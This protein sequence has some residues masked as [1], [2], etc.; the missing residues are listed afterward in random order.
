[1]KL[2][3]TGEDDL[4]FVFV[5]GTWSS[6]D[7]HGWVGHSKLR[8]KLATAFPKAALYNYRWSGANGVVARVS[9]ATHLSEELSKPE[10]SG[11]RLLAVSHSHGGNVTAWASLGLTRP[12][13]GAVFM[14]TPFIYGSFDARVWPR[15]LRL[16]LYVFAIA[17]IFAGIFACFQVIETI[18]DFAKFQS[19]VHFHWEDL[20]WFL[21]GIFGLF[22]GGFIVWFTSTRLRENFSASRDQ[23][24]WYIG[25][26]PNIGRSF[27]VTAC[28]DEAAAALNSDLM[29]RIICRGMLRGMRRVL[30]ALAPLIIVAALASRILPRI[31][32]FFESKLFIDTFYILVTLLV[33]TFVLQLALTAF[34]F[35]PIDSALAFGS[36]ICTTTAPV[37]TP[38]EI[39]V[40]PSPKRN[41][42]SH[43]VYD[44]EYAVEAIIEWLI[45]HVGGDR[46]V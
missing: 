18:L 46:R 28:G 21:A 45:A 15:I 17:S 25:K 33:A 4:A 37:N 22:L 3:V 7:D 5:H 20:G 41:A 39:Y 40:A 29:F 43:A 30:V 11:K 42:M 14:S 12:L 9:A 16:F 8:S 19:R 32:T 2:D 38:C 13:D 6:A 26:S 44:N 36:K 24:A 34:A 1:M 10:F 31:N 35:G 27:V 23:M